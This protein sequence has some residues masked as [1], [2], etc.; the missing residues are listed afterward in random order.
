[1]KKKK[2][3]SIIPAPELIT[4]HI[5]VYSAFIINISF[6]I[7][8]TYTQLSSVTLVIFHGTFPGH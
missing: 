7:I 4:V 5:L 2:L 1:M 6:V 3:L 8:I